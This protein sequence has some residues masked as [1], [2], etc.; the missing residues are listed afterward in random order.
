MISFVWCIPN[1][2]PEKVIDI[3]LGSGK[4]KVETLPAEV[5]KELM[6]A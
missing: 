2:L 3:D 6:V 4:W 5:Y 1:P